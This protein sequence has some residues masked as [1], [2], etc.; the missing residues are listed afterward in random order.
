MN[1][2]VVNIQKSKEKSALVVEK[3][4]GSIKIVS[5]YP[6]HCKNS[7]DN[8]ERLV[9]ALN[10]TLTTHSPHTRDF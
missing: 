4:Y 2:N 8:F 6:R 9:T 3:S 5:I 1:A 10:E 7:N